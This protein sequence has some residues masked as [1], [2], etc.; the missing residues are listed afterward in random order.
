MAN[1]QFYILLAKAKTTGPEQGKLYCMYQPVA[2]LLELLLMPAGKRVANAKWE[3]LADFSFFP[4]LNKE[5]LFTRKYSRKEM[6]SAVS[7][8]IEPA[9]SHLWLVCSPSG[10]NWNQK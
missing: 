3:S 1:P 5:Q 4:F 9:A 8:G 7:L 10:T 6:F 2:P